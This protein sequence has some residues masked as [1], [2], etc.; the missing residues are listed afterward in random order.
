MV[1]VFALLFFLG[2]TI[3]AQA[4]TKLVLTQKDVA[5]LVLKQSL[6]TKEVDLKYQT[7][8]LAPIL[9]LDELDW[10]FGLEIGNQTDKSE[11]LSAASGVVSDYDTQ[12]MLTTL[13]LSKSWITGTKTTVTFGRTSNR[14]NL[15]STTITAGTTVI[16]PATAD[17]LGFTLE[18]SLWN[19]FF[20][21]THRAQIKSA[22][23]LYQSQVVLRRGELQDAVLEGLRI[24]WKAY[25]AQEN[26]AES[27]NARERYEKLSAAVKKKSSLGYSSPGEL[28]QALAESEV[29]NQK[30]KTNS[31]AYL[32]ALHELGEYLNIDKNAEVELRVPQSIPDLPLLKKISV[33]E[34]RPIKSQK[35]KIESK[36]EELLYTQ[37]KNRPVLNL[38]ASYTGTGVDEKS[39]QSF[40]EISSGSHPNTYVGI[41]F[42]YSFGSNSAAEQELNGRLNRDLEKVKLAQQTRELENKILLAEKKVEE[43]YQLALSYNKHKDL[44]E[45]ALLEL[46]KTYSQGRTDISILIE[47][48]NKYFES[49]ISLVKSIGDYYIALNEWAAVRDELIPETGEDK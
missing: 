4:Q 28:S 35:L 21:Q 19:N 22:E 45:K 42:A 15:D 11:N 12:K 9:V 29:R 6:H 33:E 23:K 41:K 20:G 7:Y 31:L 27:L 47:A 5:D 48:M 17:S 24:Y 14:A 39:T 43:T 18:Q 16:N 46:N 26:F 32:Q 1:K 38:V 2:S 25:V 37:S 40:N 30:V 8:R 44:R 36:E 10:T 49:E 34:L 13:S 3:G